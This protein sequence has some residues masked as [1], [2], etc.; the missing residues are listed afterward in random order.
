[1]ATLTSRSGATL[2][3]L[4]GTACVGTDAGMKASE[5]QLLRRYVLELGILHAGDDECMH[6]EGGASAVYRRAL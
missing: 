1:M 4:V 6:N 3:P 2:F 5:Y